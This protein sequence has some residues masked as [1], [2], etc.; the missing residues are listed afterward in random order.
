[1][2]KIDSIWWHNSPVNGP[3][4]L[5]YIGVSFCA[6]V[7]NGMIVPEVTELVFENVPKL[8][9]RKISP[10]DY[11][12][13]YTDGVLYEEYIVKAYRDRVTAIFENSELYTLMAKD[14]F[15][16]HAKGAG[17]YTLKNNWSNVDNLA[18]QLHKII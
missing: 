12:I 1:V 9:D 6:L 16:D 3:L 13:A 18:K 5:S 17:A 10:V 2:H 14:G 15:L 7:Q 8:Q 4:A 11:A